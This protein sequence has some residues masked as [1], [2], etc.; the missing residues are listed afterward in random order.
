ALKKYGL[1]R[2]DLTL[3]L[4]KRRT[5]WA[6]EKRTNSARLEVSAMMRRNKENRYYRPEFVAQR[7]KRPLD[8]TLA[9]I[10]RHLLRV[11]H[12]TCQGAGHCLSPFPAPV[13]IQGFL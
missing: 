9:G 4:P 2:P 7:K 12:Y 11:L 8:A 5:P 3:K 13:G 6:R 1:M 10:S